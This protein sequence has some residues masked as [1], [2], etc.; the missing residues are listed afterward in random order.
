MYPVASG[1]CSA[2]RNAKNLPRTQ[3]DEKGGPI[4]RVGSSRT[5]ARE[6]MPRDVLVLDL[7]LACGALP[8]S[9]RS[10]GAPAQPAPAPAPSLPHH[11]NTVRWRTNQYSHAGYDVYR[12][13]AQSG[14]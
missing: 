2:T 3:R 11:T 4:G 5:T 9:C 10:A 13:E 14:P 1:T 7:L 12:A 8:L 6:S